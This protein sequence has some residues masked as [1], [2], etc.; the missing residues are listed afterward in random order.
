MA[1]LNLWM[2]ESPQLVC[3][4]TGAWYGLDQA[5]LD[6]KFQCQA[7]G[8]S[9]IGQAIWSQ[10][11][12]FCFT[13]IRYY[14]QGLLLVPYTSVPVYTTLASMSGLYLAWGEAAVGDIV[15][16]FLIVSGVMIGNWVQLF[17]LDTPPH[18]AVC[19]RGLQHAAEVDASSQQTLSSFA[20]TKIEVWACGLTMMND[21]MHC[22]CVNKL[23][24]TLDMLPY[25]VQQWVGC[26]DQGDFH[27][28]EVSLDLLITSKFRSKFEL[29][30]Y[31][32]HVR[33]AAHTFSNSHQSICNVSDGDRSISPSIAIPISTQMGSY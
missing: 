21:I 8:S 19:H 27:L 12:L 13:Y 29:C 9:M 23:V 14:C 17:L 20:W 22:Y 4:F 1:Y 24:S 2:L 26:K 30:S 16:G 31:P 6:L 3:W 15:G 33:L 25:C 11:S 5:T 10:V 18:V 7:S 32:I 28:S